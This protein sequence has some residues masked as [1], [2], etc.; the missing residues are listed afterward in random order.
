MDGIIDAIFKRCRHLSCA[1][2]PIYTFANS[3]IAVYCIQHA[4]NVLVDVV[5]KGCIAPEPGSPTIVLE[6]SELFVA[7]YYQQHAQDGMVGVADKRYMQSAWRMRLSYKLDGI[8]K[9][10]YCNKHAHDGMANVCS[11]RCANDLLS[12]L[13]RT[14]MPRVARGKCTLQALLGCYLHE[15]LLVLYRL[16]QDPGVRKEHPEDGMVNVRK[17]FRS[18]K[19]CQEVNFVLHSGQ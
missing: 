16:R 14:L 12:R 6:G 10:V 17:R 1:W 11:K 8:K 18:D 5:N 7:V 3:T 19:A 9:D 13:S 15:A 4:R 2:L